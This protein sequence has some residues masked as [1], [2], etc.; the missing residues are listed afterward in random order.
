MIKGLE[1]PA[2]ETTALSEKG[3][4]LQ[5]ARRRDP[6]STPSP[7]T[8]GSCIMGANRLQPG[9]PGLI[10]AYFNGATL[11]PRRLFHHSG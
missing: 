9:I 11:K 8:R 1:R 4:E 10:A 5:S 2:A 3:I 7:E 6:T